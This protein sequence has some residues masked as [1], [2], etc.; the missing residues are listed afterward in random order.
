MDRDPFLGA[1]GIPVLN[2]SGEDIP[3]YGVV[4]LATA[5]T[6]GVRTVDAPNADNDPHVYV[7]GAG[8]LHNGDRGFVRFLSLGAI[9]YD[10]ADGEPAINAIYGPKRGSFRVH[11]GYFGFRI[12]GEADGKTV[13][14]ARVP[15]AFEEDYPYPYGSY[16]DGDGGASVQ[17]DAILNLGCDADDTGNI[18]Y[19]SVRYTTVGLV[20]R[21]RLTLSISMEVLEEDVVAVATE[22]KEV[23]LATS[24][25]ACVDGDIVFTKNS[26]KVRVI[27]CKACP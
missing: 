24:T 26:E 6:D 5:G 4:R 20:R 25:I 13:T 18:L 19:D 2:S 22:C 8:T 11:P 7:N 9:A 27:S 1:P 16:D 15:E 17:H 14:A 23:L 3:P 12:A 21:G 10:A